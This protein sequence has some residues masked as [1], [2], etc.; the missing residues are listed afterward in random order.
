MR[1]RGKAGKKGESGFG[2]LRSP[3]PQGIPM[4]ELIVKRFGK[5]V[6]VYNGFDACPLR[7]L[8]YWEWLQLFDIPVK[9]GPERRSK[10]R[11]WN[12]NRILLFPSLE[13]SGS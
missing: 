10:L 6:Y 9:E 8:L 11:R 12:T 2:R 13:E 1:R 7:C 5:W 4:V 3:A